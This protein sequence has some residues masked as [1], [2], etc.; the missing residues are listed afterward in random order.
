MFDISI[1][2]Y[3][4]TLL[5]NIDITDTNLKNV[6]I[7]I[8]GSHKKLSISLGKVLWNIDIN[9]GKKIFENIDI[10]MDKEIL[11]NINIDRILYS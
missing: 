2:R 6:D 8:K 9:I 5:K 4:S 3:I 10:D 7:A 1:S 11:K